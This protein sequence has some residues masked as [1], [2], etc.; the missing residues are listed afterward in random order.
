MRQPYDM[1]S[2]RSRGSLGSD[3]CGLL[4]IGIVLILV[5]YGLFFLWYYNTVI[6]RPYTTEYTGFWYGLLHGIFI[7]PSFFVSLFN[8]QV[9][10]YQSPNN[11]N[12]Y[13]FG[14]MLG[15]GALFGSSGSSSRRR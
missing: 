4:V 6:A 12:W 5:I 11:G 3:G 2:R 15:C 10:I 9:A 13:N 1:R 14:F 7:F 8:D